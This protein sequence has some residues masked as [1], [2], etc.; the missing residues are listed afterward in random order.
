MLDVLFISGEYPP[1]VG[2]VGDYTVCLRRA[3]A[4]SGVD[5]AVLSR[6]QVRRWDARALMWLLR[7]APRR[8]IVHIQFQA[9][10]F[11]LLGD[12]CLM[13]LLLRLAR[14]RVRVLTTFHDVRVPYLFPRAGVLRWQ[15]VKLLARTSHAVVAADERDLHAVG[16]T[17]WQVP[18][19]SNVACA[20]PYGYDRLAFR[21]GLGLAPDTLAVAYF[22][23]L[24]ASKGLDTLI[25]AFDLVRSARPGARLLMLGGSVGASYPSDAVT[26]SRLRARLGHSDVQPTGW[27]EPQALSAHLLAADVALLPY[28]DGASAR[29][30]SLLACATHGLPIVSTL[31]ASQA[32]ADAIL[33]VPATAAALGEAVL[34]LADDAALRSRVREGAA[35]LT[36][37]TRWQA[38]AEQHLAIY[39]ALCSP[40]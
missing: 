36:E 30:G 15:A 34:R 17:R 21:Q 39:R 28:A 8:G 32:V 27:L 16:R 12:V 37:R 7:M 26:A 3:L 2:G 20:P 25:D 24:N 40:P 22:G 11:D 10:A 5:S 35:A 13:P 19:G 38:I 23:L 6:R 33:A 4:S 31:P 1:D 29:R 9:G 18:I 14:P